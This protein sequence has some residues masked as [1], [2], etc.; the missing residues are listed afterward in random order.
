MKKSAGK[1]VAVII[2]ANIFL[3]MFA[4]CG[5]I[6]SKF[7]YSDHLDEKVR[8]EFYSNY[9]QNLLFLL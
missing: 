6:F 3:I 7:T 4:F 2:I 1:A 9:M 8:V 5:H